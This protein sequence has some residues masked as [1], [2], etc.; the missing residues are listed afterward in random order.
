MD[1]LSEPEIGIG[2][3]TLGQARDTGQPG[4]FECSA[5][6]LPGLVWVATFSPLPARSGGE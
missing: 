3:G 5:R 6:T 2:P 4:D 1:G